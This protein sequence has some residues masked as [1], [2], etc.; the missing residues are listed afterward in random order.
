[1]I[2]FHVIRH[3]MQDRE[4]VFFSHDR[5]RIYQVPG[6]DRHIGAGRFAG[7]SCGDSE[8]VSFFDDD[9]DVV[10]TSVIDEIIARLDADPGLSAV[11][12]DEKVSRNGV[13]RS[14]IKKLSDRHILSVRDVRFVHHLVVIRRSAIAPYLHLLRGW[15]EWCEFSLWVTMVTAGHR[16]EWLDDYGYTWV[17]HDKNAH[18]LKI[19][20]TQDTVDLINQMMA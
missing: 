4:P 16:F 20:P 15:P 2:D 14:S 18:A 9:G 1:M 8:Y 3:P 10:N 17:V 19:Q 7:F 6:V 13:V 5:C 11:C 12:T